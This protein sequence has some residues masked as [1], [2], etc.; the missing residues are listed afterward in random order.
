MSQTVLSGY[1]STGYGNFLVRKGMN[2]EV[3]INL[4]NNSRFS[5]SVSFRRFYADDLE[6]IV[7]SNSFLFWFNFALI[8]RDNFD[9]R[10]GSGFTY[11]EF[12]FY[13]KNFASPGNK[14]GYRT[15]GL[16]I[17]SAEFRYRIT[18]SSKIGI[19]YILTPEDGDALESI[20]L[21]YYL[22]LN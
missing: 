7:I 13:D 20:N 14:K 19:K 4:E 15:V 5:N 10:L 17:G 3:G 16:G 1:V 8:K 6:D 22:K 18:D 12:I 11:Y 2:A 9:F 21:S